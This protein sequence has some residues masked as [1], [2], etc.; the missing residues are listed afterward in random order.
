M[1]RRRLRFVGACA[2][3]ATIGLVV[4]VSSVSASSV[5]TTINVGN[6]PTAVSSDG[7]HVW[8]VGNK[9]LSE[10]VISG[11]PAGGSRK[12]AIKF[13][14][15][16]PENPSVGG[17]Y[18]VKAIGG[19]S[20]NPVRFSTTE[21]SLRVCVLETSGPRVTF[22]GAGRCVIDATQAGNVQFAPAPTA[23]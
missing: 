11:L 23:T 21:S 6:A 3:L 2:V 15:K 20:G 13:T 5:V 9:G 22:T 19:K 1:A 7:T 12:Q 18:T 14:S 17:H 10:I 4:G 16:P 8:V